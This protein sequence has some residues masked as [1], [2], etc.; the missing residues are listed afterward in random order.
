LVSNGQE[1]KETSLLTTYL[2]KRI[3]EPLGAS[4]ASSSKNKLGGG[5]KIFS[6]S[7]GITLEI[8]LI[9]TRSSQKNLSQSTEQ[10]SEI[11]TS[12]TDIGPLR[13]LKDLVREK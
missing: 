8:S 6:W 12:S 2:G 5:E 4:E 1:I 7:R 13:A 3:L 11:S 9:K 10:T